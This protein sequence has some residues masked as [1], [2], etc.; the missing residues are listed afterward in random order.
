MRLGPSRVSSVA[1]RSAV[2]PVLVVPHFSRVSTS[3]SSLTRRSAASQVKAPKPAPYSNFGASAVGAGGA[4]SDD[5]GDVDVAEPPPHAGGGYG[6]YGGAAIDERFS[7]GAQRSPREMP[8]R[9]SVGV[10]VEAPDYVW[11]ALGVAMLG[12]AG[13]LLW[14]RSRRR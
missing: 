7:G 9:S 1:P 14:K 10:S 5:G 4:S 12:A 8:V 3:T 13:Y 6:D 2:S 11:Y